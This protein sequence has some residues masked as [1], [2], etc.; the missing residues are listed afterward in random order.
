MFCILFVYGILQ[1]VFI[2][3]L[4]CFFVSMPSKLVVIFYGLFNYVNIFCE[5]DHQRARI[6]WAYLLPLGENHVLEFF[7]L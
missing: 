2:M 5:M 1:I 7:L 4:S 6:R 3:F